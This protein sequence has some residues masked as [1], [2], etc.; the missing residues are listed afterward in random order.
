MNIQERNQLLAERTTLERM[1]AS[2]PQSSVIDR[3]SLEARKSR[4]EAALAAALSTSR[5][6]ARARLTFRGKP[7]VGS[8]GVYAEFGAK[9]ISAFADA[10]AA[11]GSSQT[12]ALGTRGVIPNRDEYQLLITGTAQG[13]FG[14]ELEEAPRDEKLFPEHSPLDEALEQ[15]YRIMEASLGTD[16]ELTEAIVDADPRAVDA[17]RSFLKTLAEQDAMCNLEFRDDVFRFTDVGQVRRS[18][19]RLQQD[20]I[21]EEDKVFRGR[22]NGVLPNRRTFEFQVADSETIIFGKVGPDIEDAA[23]I[24]H[25]LSQEVSIHVH[26]KRAGSGRPKHTLLSWENV[27]PSTNP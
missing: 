5:E 2:I 11:I 12:K 19:E 3:M 27:G 9:A 24:N 25:V 10:V 16:D 21:H 26:S 18:L 4:V 6:P 8:H 7:I 14:F 13:S 20:N 15:T 17:L 22:F 23:S 1:L